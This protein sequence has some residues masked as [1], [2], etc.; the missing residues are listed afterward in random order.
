MMTIEDYMR[1]PKRRLAEMLVERDE[2]EETIED[3]IAEKLA[4]VLKDFPIRPSYPLNPNPIQ[5]N[6]LEPAVLYGC[7][8]IGDGVI[9]DTKTNQ[10]I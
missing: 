9:Y 1:L 8:S 3:K 7:P 2:L 6:P 4:D 5:P 10:T